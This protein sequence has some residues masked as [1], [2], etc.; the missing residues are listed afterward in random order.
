MDGITYA[1]EYSGGLRFVETLDPMKDLPSFFD[2]VKNQGVKDIDIEGNL[3]RVEA[4]HNF[5]V[6]EKE[7]Y[8]K[9]HPEFSVQDLVPKADMSRGVEFELKPR[10]SGIANGTVINDQ[11]VIKE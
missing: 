7:A 3:K 6:A 10:D 9:A 5:S 1:L 11:D 4:L 2:Y 8:M